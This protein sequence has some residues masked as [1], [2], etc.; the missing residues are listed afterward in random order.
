MKEGYLWRRWHAASINIF[1]RLLDEG[2]FNYTE[3][4]S[5]KDHKHDRSIHECLYTVVPTSDLRWI[6]GR[7]IEK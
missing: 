4:D 1:L 5:C 2:K 7:A 3:S 6:I